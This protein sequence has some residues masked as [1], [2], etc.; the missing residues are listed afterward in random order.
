[1]PLRIVAIER[2]PDKHPHIHRSRSDD[3]HFVDSNGQAHGA[4]SEQTPTAR[5]RPPPTGARARPALLRHSSEGV[6]RAITV[7]G[8]RDDPYLP[9]PGDVYWVDT[10]I[11]D[12][13]DPK[14]KRPA[15]VARVPHSLTGRII[16]V[17]RTTDLTR[18]PGVPSPPD[19]S[20]QLNKPGIWGYV[21]SAEASLWTPSMVTRCGVGDAA[22]LRAVRQEFQL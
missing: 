18:T 6:T 4:S 3:A 17:T 21:A 10:S 19:R 14:P 5:A 16:L 8:L 11:L 12:N 7:F 1:M 15:L 2:R 22:H 13:H 20:L 9:N